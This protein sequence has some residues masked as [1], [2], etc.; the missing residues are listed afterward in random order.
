MCATIT[1]FVRGFV[2]G[3]LHLLLL[4]NPL[5]PTGSVAVATLC[6]L[7]GSTASAQAGEVARKRFDIPRGTRTREQREA[8][9]NRIAAAAG[10]E[11]KAF[12]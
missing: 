11:E 9:A 10:A 2:S 8:I 7:A 1:R 4:M 5:I 12:G 3:V 6:C